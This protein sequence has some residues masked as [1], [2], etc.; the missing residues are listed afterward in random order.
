VSGFAYWNQNTGQIVRTAEP[1][2]RLE[3]LPV[4]HPF[5]PAVRDE[6][7]PAPV[8]DGVLGGRQ[9]LPVIPPPPAPAPDVPPAVLVDS[10]SATV[11]PAEAEAKVPG[12]S[13]SKADWLAFAVE[14]R[15]ADPVAAEQLNRDQLAEEYGGT[16]AQD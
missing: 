15:G 11:S 7:A 14:H 3:R 6:D 9:P 2:A 16:D 10:P 4:W 5:D 12:K 8:L 13:A 1:N